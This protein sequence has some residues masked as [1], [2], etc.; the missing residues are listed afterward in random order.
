M[1]ETRKRAR[2]IVAGCESTDYGGDF[3]GVEIVDLRAVVGD[4]EEFLTVIGS[5]RHSDH[6]IFGHKINGQPSRFF[7]GGS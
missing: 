4:S 2:S 3:V 5:F 6:R 1:P 7:L